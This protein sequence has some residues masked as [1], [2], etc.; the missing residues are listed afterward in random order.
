MLS[1]CN[2]AELYMA[3]DDPAAAKSELVSFLSAFHDIDAGAIHPHGTTSR[4]SKPRGISSASPPAWTR[5]SSA[6]RRFSAR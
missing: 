1:T 4:I 2:R 5:S 3:C 6:S